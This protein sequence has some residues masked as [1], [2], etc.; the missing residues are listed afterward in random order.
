MTDNTE[1]FW[2]KCGELFVKLCGKQPEEGSLLADAVPLV[3]ACLAHVSALES[4]ASAAAAQ[5]IVEHWE[6]SRCNGQEAEE[7][8]AAVAELNTAIAALHRGK[9]C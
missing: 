7:L 6:E 3:D 2:R 1:I 8:S 5:S 9:T 4:V